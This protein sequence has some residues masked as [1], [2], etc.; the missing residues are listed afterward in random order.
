MVSLLGVVA[1]VLLTVPAT[2]A[3][4]A[5]PCDTTPAA[6][7]PANGLALDPTAKD[8]ADVYARTDEPPRLAP[9][10]RPP[11]YPREMMQAGLSGRVVMVFILNADGTV[12]DGS[13][14]LIESPHEQFTTVVRQ[15]LARTKY[16]PATKGGVPVAARVAQGVTFRLAE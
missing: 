3:A 1:G 11:Q 2:A 9:G 10:F 15:M 8:S 12:R 6:V 14:R 5:V 13:L 4:S 7:F 16:I